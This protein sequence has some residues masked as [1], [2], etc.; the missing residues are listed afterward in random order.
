MAVAE[1]TRDGIADDLVGGP[2]MPGTKP[3]RRSLR[4]R[5]VYHAK[6]V[7]IGMLVVVVPVVIVG[8][9]LQH[10]H[11]L[12]SH[13]VAKVAPAVDVV[14]G[15]GVSLAILCAILV[16]C[17]VLGWLVIRTVLG[18]HLRDWER[19]KFLS[20]SPFLKKYGEK[21]REKTPD[22]AS[23]VQPVLAHVAGGWQP[24]VIVDEHD[25]G[26]ATVFVPTIPAVATGRLYCLRDEQIL[27]LEMPLDEFK[28]KLTTSGHRSQEWL[29]AVASASRK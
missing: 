17:W 6:L 16:V 9:T 20:R 29:Q 10:A 14:G 8:R 3:D 4:G 21:L 24:G 2:L 22:A 12:M 28:Q 19:E 15:V 1:D 11:K 7:L 26:W 27:R 13:G 5:T 25:D 18:Q 23:A